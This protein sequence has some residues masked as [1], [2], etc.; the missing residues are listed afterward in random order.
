[1]T[2]HL[3]EGLIRP[4][5]Q[6]L[7]DQLGARSPHAFAVTLPDGTAYRSGNA[8]PAFTLAFRSDAALLATLTRGHLGL[9]ESYFDGEVDVAGSLHAAFATGLMAQLD[10]RFNPIDPLQNNLLEWRQSN[11]SFEQAKANA[12]AHYGLP[13]AFYELWL[14]DAL[15][16]YTCGYWPEGVT[17]LEQ[18]QAAKI[19][20]VCR[21]IRLQ[22]G[23]RF[24]DIGCGFGGFML[25]AHETV[26]AAGTG[27][28]NTT[29][30]VEW[31]RA[32]IAE[33][34]LGARLQVRE[35]DFREVD[36]PYDKVVSIGVLEHAGRDQLAEVV[37]A[38]A[39][40]LKPGGLGLLHFIGHVGR[41]ETERF[42]RKHV[43]PGGWIPSL[44][45]VIVELERCG[46]EVVDIENLRRHY[47]LTLDAWAGRFE[48]RW[49]EIRALDP[50]RFDERFRRIWL[51][52]LVGCAEMFR[53]PAERTHL[54]QIV[55][56]KGNVTRD[57]YPMGRG[58]LYA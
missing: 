5:A 1:M 38:H 45:D 52:Y 9:L 15:R 31:L 56:S 23:E 12:R 49:D 21:K 18:A 11:R 58:F 30:Q 41:Y 51:T 43:F 29:E 4:F 57:G 42:I 39:D 32:R 8:A 50:A 28:N 25:R 13:A 3:Q 33:R 19:D 53:S 36:G 22:P 27:I 35:A 44:A 10:P 48:R 46:L 20:H 7:I 37:K 40:F 24:V 26:G 55:F 54:F 6:K 34:G 14:D 16:M 17:T 47:A 2:P